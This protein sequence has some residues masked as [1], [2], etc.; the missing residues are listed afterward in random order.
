MELRDGPSHVTSIRNYRQIREAGFI[1]PNDDTVPFTWAQTKA[2]CCYQLG[3]VSL[4]DFQSP[5][6]EKIFSDEATDR[7]PTVLT[8]HHPTTVIM[9]LDRQS[10]QRNILSY[11]E[12]KKRADAGVII[13]YGLEVGYL[14]EIPIQYIKKH[15]LACMYECD[16]HDHKVLSDVYDYKV[17]SESMVLPDV[18]LKRTQTEHVRL[19]E[20]L[21]KTR[22]PRL[23]ERNVSLK[24]I[25]NESELKKPL[26][27]KQI[28]RFREAER[29]RLVR[30]DL[31]ALRKTARWKRILT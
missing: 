30:E 3:A 6:I 4:F 27:E 22:Q 9:V 13:P 16:V 10:L 12:I 15:V 25:Y 2:S 23:L 5:S 1:K 11:D 18:L 19:L 17:I 26:T 20:D 24:K 31:K 21:I 14:G 8:K 29:K 7:W 28:G